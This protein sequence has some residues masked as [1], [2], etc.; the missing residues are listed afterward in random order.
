METVQTVVI[1][2]GVVGLACARAL[3]IAGHEVVIVEAEERIGS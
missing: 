3:A 2:A 1:G